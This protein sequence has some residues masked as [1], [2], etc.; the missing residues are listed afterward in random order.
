MSSVTAILGVYE[1]SY[2]TPF[3]NFPVLLFYTTNSLYITTQERE[4]RAEK[5]MIKTLSC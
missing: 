1:I 3:C 5:D 4:I 2:V